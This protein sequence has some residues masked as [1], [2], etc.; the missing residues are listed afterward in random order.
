M[1]TQ[2]VAAHDND[3]GNFMCDLCSDMFT[4][5]RH[6]K[7]HS[8]SKEN[9]QLGVKGE[10]EKT[11]PKKSNDIKNLNSNYILDKVF[12]GN[13]SLVTDFKQEPKSC[14]DNTGLSS[15]PPNS[16]SENILTLSKFPLT[17]VKTEDI[18]LTTFPRQRAS[19]ISG[20]FNVDS[21]SRTEH[22]DSRDSAVLNPS[23]NKDKSV[24]NISKPGFSQS[25]S[26]RFFDTSEF[27]NSPDFSSLTEDDHHSFD[28][29]LRTKENNSSAVDNKNTG[30]AFAQS[31]AEKLAIGKQFPHSK[32]ENIL[33]SFAGALKQ[34]PSVSQS[35]SAIRN[36]MRGN[37]VS[38][39]VES[40]RPSVVHSQ[41]GQSPTTGGGKHSILQSAISSR[42]PGGFQMNPLDYVNYLS[43]AAAGSAK[44]KLP[45]KT[46]SQ[47]SDGKSPVDI[48]SGNR[49]S[50][51]SV[52]DMLKSAPSSGSHLKTQL[53]SGLDLK[54]QSPTQ[55]PP[56][57]VL[58]SKFL[59]NKSDLS[60]GKSNLT[61]QGAPSSR[62]RQPADLSIFAQSYLS[63]QLVPG[64]VSNVGN[65]PDIAKS[66]A[67]QDKGRRHLSNLLGVSDTL[68]SGFMFNVEDHVKDSDKKQDEGPGLLSHF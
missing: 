48:K 42:I 39:D 8:C 15:S 57:N 45:P 9:S 2:H 50:A 28:P 10:L 59:S 56:A 51:H 16:D 14:D 5:R 29:F 25:Q 38:S 46:L 37:H 18:G 26:H 49:S 54:S 27:S 40:A 6:L 3:S 64:S 65:H 12:S 60:S 47:H 13:N 63:H 32:Q 21:D 7:E 35:S 24:R 22:S 44:Q 41:P 30:D 17:T 31:S 62:H 23:K 53:Q 36:D 66:S 1:F 43:K 19:V 61:S 67:G 11:L 52:L 68:P 4:V 55:N 34:R 58:K 33:L 20:T